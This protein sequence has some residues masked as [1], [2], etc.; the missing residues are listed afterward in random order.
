VL[1]QDP[2]GRVLLMRAFDPAQ[3]GVR[4]WFTIG[5][6]L[7]PGEGPIEGALRELYEETGL[8]LAA[9]DL[10]GPVHR[11]DIEF[12]FAEY[13]ITQ[14]QEFFVAAAPGGWRPEPAGLDQIELDTVD[15]WSWWSLEQLLAQAAG[16]PHDG[17]GEPGETV[18][19]AVL[20]E[21]LTRL[22]SAERPSGRPLRSP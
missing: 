14:S 2:G 12:G 20:P 6:G 7:E 3:P 21:L 9:A 1:L 13:W 8:R 17:P 19:P 10:A 15:A 18:Y 22:R 11:E 16:Q 4:F 5:G